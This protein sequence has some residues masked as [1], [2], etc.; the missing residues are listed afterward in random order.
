MLKYIS[1]PA[2]FMLCFVGACDT[3][4]PTRSDF[5]SSTKFDPLIGEKHN[6]IVKDA[7]IQAKISSLNSFEVNTRNLD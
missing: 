7:L 2:L 4:E 3:N 5:L 1:I 6:T